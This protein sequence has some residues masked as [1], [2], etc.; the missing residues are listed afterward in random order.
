MKLLESAANAIAG[1]VAAKKNREAAEKDRKARMQM[2]ESMDFKP[3]YA[4]DT[5]PTF[6]RTESPVARSY[7][8][9]FLMGT[10][11]NATFSGAP[12]AQAVKANQ[13]AMENQ[14]FGTPQQRVQRQQQILQET[15]WKVT[16]PTQG[17]GSTATPSTAATNPGQS[18]QSQD[19]LWKAKNPDWAERGYTRAELEDMK[20]RGFLTDKFDVDNPP[21]S[22]ATFWHLDD[23]RERIKQDPNLR[24]TGK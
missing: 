8:E 18:A 7:L 4:S 2:I 24:Y 19:A 14:T 12:N 11:P 21:R 6:Q 15:P 22:S 16:A 9:S 3:M 10:N 20:G 1:A 5:T 17:A 23:L 13:Q